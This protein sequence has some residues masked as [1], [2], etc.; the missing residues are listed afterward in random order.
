MEGITDGIEELFGYNQ[1]S[2]MF[3]RTL[4]Q[5]RDYQEQNM[6][7]KQ[8]MLYREDVRDLTKLTTSKMDSYLMITLLEL[9]ICLDMLVHGIVHIDI[10]MQGLNYAPSWLPWLYMISLAE[11]FV[12]LF[13]SAWLAIHASVSAHS[14]S[15]RLLT[16]YVRL[17]LPNKGQLDAASATAVDFEN[18]G[19]KEILR[20]P[21][22][23]KQAEILRGAAAK[24]TAPTAATRP[25]GFPV[26]G[27]ALSQPDLNPT[28]AL[29][30][31]RLY[32]DLQD[33]WQAHDAYARACLALGTYKLLHSLAYYTIGLLVIELRAPWAALGCALILP[34]LAW[35][36]IRLDLYFESYR[37]VFG[38]MLL[39]SGP[40]L[41]LVA[42]T[43]LALPTP[44]HDAQQVLV[45]I[46]FA[47]HAILIVCITY[48]AQAE[49]VSDHGAA[50]PT[51]F[52]SVLYL[53]VFGWLSSPDEAAAQTTTNANP[54]AE[55]VPHNA[56]VSAQTEAP[57]AM[58]PHLRQA[59]CGES[60]QLGSQLRLEFRA[61]EATELQ[62]LPL[63]K[64]RL[65]RLRGEFDT[66]CESFSKLLKDGAVSLSNTSEESWSSDVRSSTEGSAANAN[67][68]TVGPP[69]DDCSSLWLRLEWRRMQWF[70][71]PWPS[72]GGTPN[73][74]IEPPEGALISDLDGIAYRLDQ[75]R[76]RICTLRT[77]SG[78][79]PRKGPL[80]RLRRLASGSQDSSP[81]SFP[82]PPAIVPAPVQASSS[83][84]SSSQQAARLV[85]R[86]A[87]VR[88]LS[89]T[90][91][92]SQTNAQ[93]LRFGGTEAAEIST[94]EE[95]WTHS[96]SAAQTFHPRRDGRRES[97]RPPG[98]VPW[99]VF[100]LA[101]S[102][103]VI[104]WVV[105]VMTYVV[106]PLTRLGAKLI[107]HF[108]SN[109]HR[110]SAPD[111][112]AK[113][114][115]SNQLYGSPALDLVVDPRLTGDHLIIDSDDWPT[116][117]APIGA[118]GLAC[119]TDLGSVVLVLDRFAVFE[120]D[121]TTVAGDFGPRRSQAVDRCLA[122]EP[123]FHSAGLSGMRLD[124]S[125]P[126]ACWL[127]LSG[128]N[129][130]ML[131]CPLGAPSGLPVLTKLA[132][133]TESSRGISSPPVPDTAAAHSKRHTSICRGA[134]CMQVASLSHQSSLLEAT[135][136]CQEAPA[137]SFLM[138]GL[139]RELDEDVEG[140][141]FVR[142]WS[143]D[144]ESF[145]RPRYHGQRRLPS[146]ERWTG[147]CTVGTHLF[148]LQIPKDDALAG[149]KL[150]RFDM[151]SEVCHLLEPSSVFHQ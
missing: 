2:F 79:E 3:D 141:R 81:K 125:K 55:P 98:Q 135:A 42:A 21:L 58:P 93:E 11:A 90:A 108:N 15:V 62:S 64:R 94:A 74:S 116:R 49:C 50:L 128:V 38:A 4:R 7:I 121:V 20:V 118:A 77:S 130:E 124:C 10:N 56:P 40:L 149:P 127:L 9:G 122:L 111:F 48:V 41:A 84:S 80:N 89:P 36:L 68:S 109:R 44:F 87:S 123:S 46:I 138:L 76:S 34:M 28:T 47:M 8:F 102:V 66:L 103:L 26:A 86:T 63:M 30:H 43:M 112:S 82:T 106:S 31:V 92:V 69:L 136:V 95:G 27:L 148:S 59:L 54:T 78:R 1:E 119:H 33:N 140:Q 134:S 115:A 97:K 117:P 144:V 23:Q 22:W 19:A 114:L 133:V 88:S 6:R 142:I 139:S 83:S 57:K 70:V 51:R 101:S 16:Q 110:R 24:S 113:F 96:E 18:S 151:P 14:F 132:N 67:S 131:R 5:Q 60:H 29:K 75:L 37:S 120:V 105:G 100:L 146:K 73:R 129:G 150:W 91:E 99:R 52:R 53:D 126:Q 145:A 39:M 25:E 147:V 85:A 104:V 35:L 45:P 72:D 65:V 143:A 32:R 137:N 71:Q 61:W 107:P 17:P 13:L 12:Y